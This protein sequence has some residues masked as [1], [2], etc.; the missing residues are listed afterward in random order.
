MLFRSFRLLQG[1]FGA[2]LVPL[3]QAVL[4]DINPKERYGQAMAMWG[5]GIMVA[6]I[7]GPTLG[8]WLT[9]SYNWRWVFFVNVPVGVLAFLGILIFL[10][11]DEKRRRRFD[12]FGF[13]MLSLGIGAL[14]MMLDRGEQ[15]DWFSSLEIWIE[16]GL[17]VSGFWAFLTHSFTSRDPFIHLGIFR[18]RNFAMGI[19]FIFVVGIVLLSSLALLPPMLEGLM[20][21]PVMTAGIVL[22]PRG[23]GTM[24][25][26]MIVGRMVSK[27][28]ARAL[29]LLGLMLT[30]WS[31]Y[32]MSEFTIV[33]TAWP[34]VI[35]GVVQGLGLGLVFVPLSTLTFATLPAVHRTDG[36]SLFSLVRNVGS[37]IG[38]SVVATVLAQYTQ[39][40]HAAIAS[41]ITP[42][43]LGVATQFPGLLSRNPLY[44][45]ELNGMVT[46]QAAMIGYVDDFLLMMYVTLAAVP[47]VFL[48]RKPQHSAAPAEAAVM[49]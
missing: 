34:V 18:D 39:A 14:Q 33:M 40:N 38:I 12:F 15:Q 7:I 47:I 8:G 2:A 10:P 6:P 25:S 21:Y 29:V 45:S 13:A 43:S 4:L 22:A 3:S 36:T 19:I 16:F 5:M 41:H 28:D 30:A 20:G 44:L 27:I 31:L 42:F 11:G 1:I 24:I 48:L 23:I 26:M 32:L 17:A 9:E 49:E 35:S 37:S 46:Q